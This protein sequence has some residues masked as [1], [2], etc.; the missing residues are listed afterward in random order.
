MGSHKSLWRERRLPAIEFGSRDRV[1]L[2]ALCDDE[3]HLLLA[4]LGF[5]RT[6]AISER[7]ARFQ[8]L[9]GAA[10]ETLLQ[11]GPACDVGGTAMPDNFRMPPECAGRRTRC[12]EQHTVE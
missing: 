2:E 8:H 1:W 4:L 6:D 11:F 10:D 3:G 12:I 5:E 9:R 7:A